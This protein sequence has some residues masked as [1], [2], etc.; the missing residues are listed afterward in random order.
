VDLD[1]GKFAQAAAADKFSAQVGLWAPHGASWV[2]GVSA[3]GKAAAEPPHSKG[4]W[5][6]V[7]RGATKP[8][9]PLR[10]AEWGTLRGDFLLWLEV[11]IEG[12]SL[13]EPEAGSL[14]GWQLF[15]RGEGAAQWF[16]WGGGV[17]HRY[18]R[19]TTRWRFEP[20]LI[21]WLAGVL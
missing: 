8:P 5:R 19:C 9:T 12:R 16:G 18:Y 2:Q 6:I 15:P 1:E 17:R 10:N 13:V 20:S 21:W 11:E 14:S 4:S 3:F 7:V